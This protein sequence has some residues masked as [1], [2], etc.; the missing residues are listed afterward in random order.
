MVNIGKLC[1]PVQRN[2]PIVSSSVARVHDVINVPTTLPTRSSV[3][4]RALKL[5]EAP[6]D[7]RIRLARWE[8]GDK[9]LRLLQRHQR[10]SSPAVEIPDQRW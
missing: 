1:Q 3:M 6:H 5:I 7:G 2:T 4:P 10:T 8:F 9:N